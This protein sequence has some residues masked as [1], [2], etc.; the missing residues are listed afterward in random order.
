MKG[1]AVAVQGAARKGLEDKKGQ[2]A[3]EKVI[4]G[5]AHRRSYR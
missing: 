4:L 5:F 2:G 3:L 1:D